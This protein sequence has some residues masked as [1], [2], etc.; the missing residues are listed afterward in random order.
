MYNISIEKLAE[1]YG[2]IYELVI[3]VAV[4][5][6]NIYKEKGKRSSEEAA[7]TEVGKPTTHAL[8]ELTDFHETSKN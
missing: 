4:R 6:R 3:A 2:N 5:A 1:P 8:L 7:E